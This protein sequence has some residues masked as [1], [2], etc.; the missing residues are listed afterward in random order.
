[1]KTTIVQQKTIG[2]INSLSLILFGI[3]ITSLIFAL[4][5]KLLAEYGIW[6]GILICILVVSTIFYS[7]KS[8]RYLRTIAW[9][10]TITIIIGIIIYL[11]GLSYVKNALEGF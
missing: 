9:S 5:I 7:K 10:M 3:L 11:A 1:M 2:I 6:L 8:G 4:S